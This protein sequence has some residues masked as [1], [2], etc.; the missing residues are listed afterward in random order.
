M[1]FVK[2]V[3]I[4]F[5]LFIGSLGSIAIFSTKNNTSNA[6]HVTDEGHT[7]IPDAQPVLE[8]IKLSNGLSIIHDHETGCQYILVT[9]GTSGGTAITPRIN[10]DGTHVCLT[11]A[12]QEEWDSAAEEDYLSGNEFEGEITE[13]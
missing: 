1:T 11:Q 13:E 12:G 2:V 5:A 3:L 8:V 4:A 10:T 9:R 7:D 6:S